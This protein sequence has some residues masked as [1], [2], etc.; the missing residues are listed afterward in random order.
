MLYP[1]RFQVRYSTVLVIVLLLMGSVLFEVTRS[2]STARQQAAR[3]QDISLPAVQPVEHKIRPV[4]SPDY[5][6]RSTISAASTTPVSMDG[7]V[8]IAAGPAG[9]AGTSPRGGAVGQSLSDGPGNSG[10]A[11]G[12]VRSASSSGYAPGS[13]GMSG[14]GAW[15]GVSGMVRA[16]EPGKA[17]APGQVKKAAKAEAPK[18][19]PKTPGSNSGGG[20]SGTSGVVATQLPAGGFTTGAAAVEPGGVAAVQSNGNARGLGRGNSSPASSPASTPEPMSVLLM[21]TGL[22]ALYGMRRRFQ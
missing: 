3:T 8:A 7:D 1:S 21:G 4:T 5:I 14:V 22:V 13:Y 19:A 9:T 17:A 20:A 2:E 18:K 15:G 10:N 16:P 6:G 12:R 11:P